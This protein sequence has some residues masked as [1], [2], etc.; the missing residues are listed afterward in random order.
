MSVK[1]P[2]STPP[3]P[4]APDPS[5]LKELGK[6]IANN[7]EASWI[8]DRVVKHIPVIIH[9]VQLWH[10]P[11]ER[12][13]APWDFALKVTDLSLVFIASSRLAEAGLEKAEGS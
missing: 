10:C 1:F 11:Q 3:A 4:P 7:T 9:L 12:R 8:R 2:N 6:K 13:G 5:W